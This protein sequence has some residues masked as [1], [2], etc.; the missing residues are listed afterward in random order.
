MQGF[1]IKKIVKFI[2]F[3]MADYD[4]LWYNMV[5]NFME[6]GVYVSKEII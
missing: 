5:N 3:S 2:H 6:V 4:G 1:L